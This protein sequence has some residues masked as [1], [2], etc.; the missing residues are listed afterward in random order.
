MLVCLSYIVDGFVHIICSQVREE[1]EC[2]NTVRK[3]AELLGIGEQYIIVEGFGGQVFYGNGNGVV[4]KFRS[5]KI[6]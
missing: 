5:E 1:R 6:T 4:R 3:A 2:E